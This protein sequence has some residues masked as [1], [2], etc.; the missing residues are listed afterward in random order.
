MPC[1]M[2]EEH[3]RVMFGRAQIA[4]PKRDR[5]CRVGQGV[6]QRDCVICC[7]SVL[8]AAFG[9]AHRLLWKSLQPQNP[10]EEDAGRDSLVDLKTNDVR[11]TVGADA[12]CDRPL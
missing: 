1:R 10:P 8:N 5:A 6:T 3:L 7:P 11:P 4:D 9:S 2:V 12:T